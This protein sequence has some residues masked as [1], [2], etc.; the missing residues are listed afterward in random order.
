MGLFAILAF[1]FKLSGLGTKING[2]VINVKLG[3]NIFENS[4]YQLN[5]TVASGDNTTHFCVTSAVVDDAFGNK[6]FAQQPKKN[7]PHLVCTDER[8]APWEAPR[9]RLGNITNNTNLVPH[10]EHK[11]I[12]IS[13]HGLLGPALGLGRIVKHDMAWPCHSAAWPCYDVA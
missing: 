8:L 5:S 13:E 7:Y 3:A 6:R 2:V 4:F 12:N 9:P 1:L 10:L 11:H